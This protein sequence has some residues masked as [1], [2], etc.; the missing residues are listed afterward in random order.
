MHHS[1]LTTHRELGP[2]RPVAPIADF[3]RAAP[4]LPGWLT[5]P[6]APVLRAGADG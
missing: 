6:D 4:T 5:H 3:V 2:N 1:V